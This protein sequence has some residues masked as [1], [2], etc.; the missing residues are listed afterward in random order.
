LKNPVRILF[1]CTGNS[2]RSQMAEGFAK[3][4]RK[5]VMEPF[6]AGTAPKEL[7]QRAVKVM[8]E[9]G[10]DIS[11]HRSKHVDE[12]ADINFDYVV[13]VCD[14]AREQCPLFTGKAKTLH[15]SFEDPAAATGTPEEVL[16]V[17][18]KVRDQ[19]KAFVEKLPEEK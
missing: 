17:F 3:Y 5:D 19:I 7:D 8:A 13:T 6:S 16:A 2:C 14:D 10:I 12:L 18:R 15:V 11:G 1:I 4:L 9:A